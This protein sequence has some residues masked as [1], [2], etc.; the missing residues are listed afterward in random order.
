[1]II[2]RIMMMIIIIMIIIIII[3]IIMVS[4]CYVIKLTQEGKMIWKK[5][6]LEN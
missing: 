5:L 4:V 6:V 2:I 3:I 1:M